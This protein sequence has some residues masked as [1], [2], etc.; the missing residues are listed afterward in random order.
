MITLQTASDLQ[1]ITTVHS[2]IVK[3]ETN[4]PLLT[5]VAIKLAEL[6]EQILTYDDVPD[7]DK[8]VAD[9]IRGLCE[10]DTEVKNA[11]VEELNLPIA[12]DNNFLENFSRDLN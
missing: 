3:L 1:V 2:L 7:S 4:N 5:K 10:R 9:I 12:G 11:V 8:D 6:T